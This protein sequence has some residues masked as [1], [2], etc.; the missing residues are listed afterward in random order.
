MPTPTDIA[1][2]YGAICLTVILVAGAVLL[3]YTINDLVRDALIRR[4]DRGCS[5]HAS[6]ESALIDQ[7]EQMWRL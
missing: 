2:A 1:V 7:L 6:S 4:R 3:T 5:R